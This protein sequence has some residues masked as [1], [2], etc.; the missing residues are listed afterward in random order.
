[1]TAALVAWRFKFVSQYSAGTVV[2]MADPQTMLGFLVG[3]WE[4][5]GRGEYPTIDSFEYRETI[6]FGTVPTKPFLTYGQRTM[7]VATEL[8]MHA[9]TGYLRPVGDDRVELVLA[10]PSG[11]VEIEEGTLSGSATGGRL[12]VRTTVVQGSTTAKHVDALVRVFEIDGD[13]LR[14]TVAMAAV[15]VALTHHLSAEL[16]RLSS[17]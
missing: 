2:V 3:T 11:I 16:H 14:Y 1:M 17:S 15:G 13:V 5:V 12:E 8:P 4:G 6:V 10:H 7:S 9:E